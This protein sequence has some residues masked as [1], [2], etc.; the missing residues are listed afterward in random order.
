MLAKFILMNN[1]WIIVL[2]QSLIIICVQ[3]QKKKVASFIILQ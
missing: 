1:D 3:A 2:R